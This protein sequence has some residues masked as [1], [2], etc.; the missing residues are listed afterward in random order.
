M[1][2]TKKTSDNLFEI[3]T[4]QGVYYTQSLVVASGGLSIP[5]M[6]ATPIGYKIAEHYRHTIM[7]TYPG[8]VPFTLHEQD[9]SK[10]EGL[11]GIAIECEVKNKRAQFNE[12]VLFTHR[13]LGGPAILQLSSYWQA[14]EEIYINLL[15]SLNVAD[16]LTEQQ[17]KSANKHLRNCL[18]D[19]LPKRLV[20]AFIDENLLDKPLQQLS[21]AN[22]KTVGKQLNNWQIKPN[23]TEGYRTAEVTLGGVNCDEISSKTMQSNLE[24]GLYFIGEVVDVTGWLGGYNFQWAW[25]SGWCAGQYV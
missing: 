16:Y 8:L 25:S 19:Y 21:K 4:N 9:K 3:A 14:G 1:I 22:I 12:N 6:C 11:S 15:P 23:A 7:P 13:G 5:K 20:S 18:A 17:E 24:E 10:Y 2:K